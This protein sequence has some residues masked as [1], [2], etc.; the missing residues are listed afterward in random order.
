M[1]ESVPSRL[2]PPR[3]APWKIRLTRMGIRAFGAVSRMR[4][5]LAAPPQAPVERAYG[6]DPREKI[7]YLAPKPGLAPRGAVLY[8]HGGGW[9]IGSK[10]TYTPFLGFLAEA[11]YPVFNVGYPLAPEN[12]HPGILRSLFRALDWIAD[13]H[14]EVTG[15]HTMGDSAGGNL[16]TMLGVLAHNPQLVADVDPARTQGLPLTCHSIVSLYGVLDR[17]SWIEDAFP[18]AD[19][20]LEA[21]AGQAAFEAEVG[22][23]LAITPMD[24]AF[25]TAP[26]ALLT[27]GSEDPL[28]RSSRIFAERLGAGSGKVLLREYPGEPHG[29]FNFGTSATADQMNADILEFLAAED[30]ASA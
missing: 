9:I 25:E 28:L 14:P 30:P 21:Y 5:T 12:P 27:V 6:D 1:S 16:C 4:R 10:D 7:T 19:M 17:L 23:D 26:P 11:G 13:Q 29:F 24:L 8:F 3:P 15:Y 22:P 18:G 20:M 2:I